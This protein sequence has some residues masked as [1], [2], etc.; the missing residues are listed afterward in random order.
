MTIT[1]GRL[2]HL[3]DGVADGPTYVSRVLPGEV[4]DGVV[5]NGRIERPRI[6][7]SSADRVR[8]PCAHYNSC[9]GCS[10]QHARDAFVSN[11]KAEI[12]RQALRAHGLPAPVRRISTSPER[13]RRRATLSG[14]RL[15]AGP[16]VG[17]HARA[18]ETITAVSDCRVLD[19]RILD[20]FPF[21]G[22][23][24]AQIGSRK[25][26]VRFHVT[27]SET[28]IDMAIDGG[29][30][31]VPSDSASIIDRAGAAGLARLSYED[32]TIATFSPPVHMFGDV[33]VAPPPRAFLQA[34]LQG[35]AALTDAVTEAVSASA[36]VADLFSGLGTFSLP[37]SRSASVHAAEGDASLIA[38]LNTA[39]RKAA[40]LKAVTT[41]VRDLFRRPLE[42][43]E[44]V[45]FDAVVM[46]PPR[47]GAEAQTSR[48]AAAGVPII[49]MVSCNPTT[50]AR[51]AR[52]LCSA[53]YQIDWID[54][55]DQ[56]RWSS[57]VELAARFRHGHIVD[58]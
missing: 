36:T 54:I 43:D 30:P 39:W 50:F 33:P 37:L 2:G 32:E 12:V 4:V 23:V 40:G 19:P 27:A 11:W 47:A 14:R 6:L 20:V 44:L 42:P 38:S 21:C 52:I 57:H 45:R 56:F 3:G 22:E 28:G 34:T 5:E 25:S 9:G 18:S 7:K 1:I 24:T 8:P 15:K 35:Q 46:D 41:E 49:A 16:V 29:R 51:D 58:A 48:L 10:L 26:D 17:F 55:I 31:L 53:G 13:S